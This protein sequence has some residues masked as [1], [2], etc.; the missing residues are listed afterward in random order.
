M[1]LQHAHW[2]NRNNAE[3]VALLLNK[4][5][6]GTLSAIGVWIPERNCEAVDSLRARI[7]SVHLSRSLFKSKWYWQL[8]G[9]FNVITGTTRTKIKMKNKRLNW[10]FTGEQWQSCYSSSCFCEKVLSWGLSER[11][12]VL[13]PNFSCP[14][15]I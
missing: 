6:R 14:G 7:H 5:L 2:D 15:V 11:M 13:W 12:E 9:D 3:N 10:S 8:R 4:T 1:R